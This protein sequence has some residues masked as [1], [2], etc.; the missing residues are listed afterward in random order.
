[1]KY[2]KTRE[3]LE[4]L[5]AANDKIIIDFFATWCGPCKMLGPVLEQLAEQR[6]DVL[7][8]KVDT[9]EALELASLFNISS[10]PT[11][12]YVKDKKTVFAELGFRPL[13]HLLNNVS[14]YLD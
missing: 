9:D 6:K 14:K 8:V 13:D 2:I 12:Y 10:I 4:Q 7:V 3:E 5:V 1:M 11:V